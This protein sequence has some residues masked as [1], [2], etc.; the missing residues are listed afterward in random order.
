MR[1]ITSLSTSEAYLTAL[2]EVWFKPDF[3]CAPRGQ[4]I[5]EVMDYSF[6][7]LHP[8]ANP[9]VTQ[10]KK[11]NKVI[12]DYTQKEMELYNSCSN[13]VE[14]FAKASKFWNKIANPDGTINSAYGY[15]IWNNKSYGNPR[16]ETDTKYE[17]CRRTP[18]TYCVEALKLDKDTRQAVMKFSLPGH[19]WIGNKDQVCTLHGNWLIR[20]DK[21]YLSV[22]MRSGDLFIGTVYDVPFFVSLMDKMIDELK[23]TY[24]DLTKGSYSHTTHSLHIYEKDETNILKMLGQ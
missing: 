14:D 22:V 17:L 10:D 11:R 7:V 9:I 13:R 23:I 12:M 16:F 20:D 21:L 8:D 6:T 24:P 3:Y 15:L 18:W 19:H 1:H 2:K 4:K 5:R